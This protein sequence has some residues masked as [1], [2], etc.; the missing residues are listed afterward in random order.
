MSAEYIR[1]ISVDVALRA[2]CC[3]RAS[4]PDSR[5]MPILLA[6]SD[7]AW[8]AVYA[9][10]RDEIIAAV[11]ADAFIAFEHFGSTS[12]PGLVAKPLIDIMAAVE[13]LDDVD[14]LIDRIEVL[15]Y[16]YQ[17]AV[18]LVLPGRTFFQRCVEGAP[19]EHLHVVVYEGENWNRHLRF[20][21]WMRS[22]PED[23]KAYDALKRQLAKLYDDTTEYS[24]AKTDYI[25]GIEAVALEAELATVGARRSR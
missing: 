12:I 7:P 19:A 13:S 25:R 3:E 6:E 8:P 14:P 1:R 9:A 16:E 20:R 15:G 18:S 22:H 23:R 10:A 17:E 5:G 21:D 11:G 4:L 24:A 2:R